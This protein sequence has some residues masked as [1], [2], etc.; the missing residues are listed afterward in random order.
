MRKVLYG[1]LVLC[2]AMQIMGSVVSVEASQTTTY[3]YTVV[4]E[5][6]GDGKSHLGRTQDAYIPERTITELGLDSPS[7]IFIDKNSVLYIADTGNK[8]IVKYEIATGECLEELKY[9]EFVTPKGVYVTDNGDIYVADSRAGALFIFDKDHN[10][11]N[12]IV[13]PDVPAFGDTPFDPHKVA[14]DENGNIYVVGEGVYGGIIQLTTDG[15]FLGFF[16][17]NEARL[18]MLQRIQ[19]II[20]TREQL[21]KLSDINPITFANVAIDYRGIVY[22]VTM[23]ETINGIKKHK[24][25]GTNMFTETLYCNTDVTDVWID[26]NL[27]V[28]SSSKSG[29]IDVYTPQGELIFEFGS[30]E[31]QLDVAG[32]FSSLVSV[33]VDASGN[34]W[35]IDG[36]KGYVQSYRQTEYAKQVYEALLLYE[37][38]Y[39]NEALEVWGEVLA[40]NQ[41]SVIAH[42]GIGNAYM[43]QYDFANA[44]EHYKIAGNHEKYSD[45]FWE[46]RNVWLQRYLAYFLIGFVVIVAAVYVINRLDKKKKIHGI[47]EVVAKSCNSIKG[48]KELFYSFRVA[49]HPLD[50][51]YDI[52][53]GKTGA[54]LGA[55]I[56]YVLLFVSFMLYMVGKGFIYQYQD[57]QE[58]DISSI[59]IGFF[60]LLGLFVICNYLVTSINDGEGSLKQVYMLLAY[61]TMP[62]II[63]F[64]SVTVLSYVVTTNEAFF[65]TVG[66]TVGA[67]W[68]IILVF[69]GLQ[70]VHNYSV[71]ETIASIVLTFVLMGIV[72]VVVMVVTIMWDQVWSF[73]STV[74]EE[75]KQYVFNR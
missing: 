9:E 22:T 36:T 49:R 35:A 73:L 20:F 54:V 42:N 45:A 3:T 4:D 5:P 41:M 7:D 66:L 50:T 43:S 53:V 75:L 25:N 69:L 21:E 56:L 71:K 65:L 60:A 19:Q 63:T 24:T 46:L 31:T 1:L 51:Y 61:G 74:W 47:T 27:F 32:L 67:V 10:L 29:Y 37:G 30:S 44:M 40:L 33:A 57:I 16:A 23:G 62:L 55:T 14:A 59:V 68:T 52:R 2:L 12:K 64:L 15:D 34:L 72:V 6:K 13:R 28:F 48:V 8:R 70:T 17:V 18:S 11:K 58:M 39:Y 26:E 38:G